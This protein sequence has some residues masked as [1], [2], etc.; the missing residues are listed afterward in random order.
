MSALTVFRRGRLAAAV[1][2][3]IALGIAGIVSAQA[4]AEAASR[5]PAVHSG[6]RVT[7][8]TTANITRDTFTEAPDGAVYYALGSTV[9]VVNGN[10]KPKTVLHASKQVMALAANSS[11]LFVQ[12]ALTVT[13]YRRSNGSAVKHW[14]LTSAF[15]PI[16]SAGLFAVGG[17]LWSWTDWGTDSSGL[18]FATVSRIGISGAAVHVVSKSAYPGDM[19][20]NAAGLF[21]EVQGSRNA[22]LAHA[23]PAGQLIIRKFTTQAAESPLALVGGRVDLLVFGSH[24]T[25]ESYSATS[26]RL[27]SSKRVSGN[28]LS[29]ADTGLGLL[30]LAEMCHGRACQTPTVGKLSVATGAVSGVAKVPGAFLLLSGPSA[31]AIEISNNIRGTIHLQRISS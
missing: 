3:A 29:I 7:L 13:E 6:P 4:G 14:G 18:E 8:G 24:L 21:F 26:L 2:P 10:A 12:T 25:I 15:K 19:S 11:D 5:A 28:D 27:L 9:L 22:G 20:A 17:T 30:V 23:T 31:A 16:T 1:V